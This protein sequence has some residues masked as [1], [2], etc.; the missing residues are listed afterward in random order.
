MIL[1][2]LHKEYRINIEGVLIKEYKRLGLKMKELNVLLILLGNNSKKNIFS[3]NSITRKS[4]YNQNEVADIIAI[5][6]DKKFLSLSLIEEKGITKEVYSLDQ[7]YEKLT[8]LF[9]EDEK[10]DLIAENKTHVGE[11][12][13]LLEQ[14]LKRPLKDL[15]LDR[16]RLWYDEF[17]F[18][19]ENIIAAANAI[20]NNF[21]V[22]YLEKLLATNYQPAKKMD[23]Q[24]EKLLDKI[25]NEL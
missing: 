4:D 22:L 2:R 6:L 13:D 19:H 11:T 24:T 1:K 7:T 8:N 16:I 25:F 9:I 10:A 14:K 15:E 12:I 18:N 3:L 21:T 23:S 20:K 17:N 5:L